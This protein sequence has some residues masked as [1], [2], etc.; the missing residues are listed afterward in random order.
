M[1]QTNSSFFADKSKTHREVTDVRFGFGQ[2]CKLLNP[3][4]SCFFADHSKTH[5]DV[6][7]VR[8]GFGQI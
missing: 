1:D 4:N 5:I 8:L 2:I 3:S 6:T 7:D